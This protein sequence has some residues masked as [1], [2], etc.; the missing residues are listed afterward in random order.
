MD[1]AV[2]CPDKHA[3]A[4]YPG[5]Y[6]EAVC[7]GKCAASGCLGRCVAAGSPDEG[8]LNADGEIGGHT[9]AKWCQ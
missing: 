3:E 7:P 6:L 8:V 9:A 1:A 4:V 5:D 2:V